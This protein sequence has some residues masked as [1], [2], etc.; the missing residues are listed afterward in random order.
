MLICANNSGSAAT[1]PDVGAKKS[2]SLQNEPIPIAG[3]V[4]MN[5]KSNPFQG[6][7][8]VKMNGNANSSKVKYW[9]DMP[10]EDKPLTIDGKEYK[11]IDDF[12]DHIK[13][14]KHVNTKDLRS[15][16]KTE[17]VELYKLALE[18]E[19]RFR[20]FCAVRTKPHNDKNYNRSIENG[21]EGYVA[22]NSLHKLGKGLAVDIKTD[23]LAEKQKMILGE[24]WEQMGHPWGGHMKKK[25]LYHY[26][27]FL[28][29]PEGDPI[30]EN[31]HRIILNS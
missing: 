26:P 9:F 31:G 5:I 2:D 16:M 12:L 4:P 27:M 19:I 10:I 21:R 17:I 8:T 29:T 20:I 23:E 30:D 14:G 25:E 3:K 6:K 18:H 24:L 11:N 15:G 28:N 1:R 13:V 22:K 7:P